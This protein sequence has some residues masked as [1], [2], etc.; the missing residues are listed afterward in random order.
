ML[1]FAEYLF[2]VIMTYIYWVL[3]KP[4]LPYGL[5]EA[6]VLKSS[7]IWQLSSVKFYRRYRVRVIIMQIFKYSWSSSGCFCRFL[8]KNQNFFI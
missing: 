2:D 6:L 5:W 8:Q 3:Y 7:L 4:N 1:V